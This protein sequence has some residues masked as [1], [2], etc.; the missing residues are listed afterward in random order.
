MKEIQNME[1]GYKH[2]AGRIIVVLVLALTV[3]GLLITLRPKAERQVN[4][5]TGFLVEVLP[6]QSKDVNMMIETY[7]T[8]KARDTLKLVAQVRGQIVDMHPSFEE[9]S[10]I[11][12]GTVIMTIDQ[13]TYQLEVDRRKVQIDQT[14]A[15][16]KRLNQE[17]QNLKAS[18]KIAKSDADLAQKEFLRLKK[19]MSKNVVAQT[20][21]DQAEQRYLASLER[22]QGLE[23][24]LALTGP[25]R[26]QLEAKRNMARVQL[27]QAELDL[28]RANIAAPFDGWVMKKVVEAGQHV[29]SGQYLGEIYSAGALDIEVHM[30]VKDLKWLPSD[31]K[32]DKMPE[33]DIIFSTTESVYI[34]KGRVARMKAQIDERTRT[35][36]VV[37]EVNEHKVAAGR[38]SI[39]VLR[40][41]MFVAVKIKGSE[42]KQVF[43]LPRYMVHNEDVVY[44]VNENRLEIRPVNV[45]RRYKDSVFIDRG[46]A[47]GELLIKSPISS[48]VNGM[49]V[50]YIQE[51]EVKRRR[52]EDRGRMTEISVSDL[53][54]CV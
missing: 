33:V 15:E 44:L 53:E 14:G 9:G 21:L 50:R 36:P 2:K 4:T 25:S 5:E 27:R 31:L 19:L 41:G 30:P 13:R 18:I 52:S 40:P 42:I 29:N 37:V 38:Q 51:S 11:P 23:N 49:P 12:K 10:F 7:G 47:D 45:L 3:Y 54:F 34:W 32:P 1:K 16:F 8:V 24:Q 48:A 28:E 20:K 43:V 26:E 46:L 39:M 17:I 22:M 6:A 35:L